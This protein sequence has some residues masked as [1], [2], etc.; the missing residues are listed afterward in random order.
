MADDTGWGAIAGNMANQLGNYAV[1][2]AANRKQYKYQQKAMAQQQQYNKDLWDYQN[3]Y[4]SP[5]Q[6]MERLKAAGLNP[7]L[8]YGSGGA[9]GGNA[10][11]IAPTEV[12]A[13]Q[14]A[15]MEMPNPVGS[16]LSARQ[17]D[18]QYKATMQNLEA[19]RVT[20]ELNQ[21]R[22]A[23]GN[24]NIMRE[25]LRSKNYKDL[26]QAEV[27]TQ[28]FVALRSGELFANEKSKGGLMDQLHEFRSKSNPK[29]IESQRLENAFKENRNRLAD[30]GIYSSDH[31]AFRVLLQ[32]AHRMG[33]DLGELLM[34]GKDNLKYLLDLVK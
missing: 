22:I 32:A 16:Y 4:N 11:P 34:K 5:Q 1:S 12:P 6:Q 30:M 21:T 24:L 20:Q 19:S 23:L 26:A 33:I 25:G 8:I 27:D 14:A 15:K 2:V 31:A 10:G 17:M 29:Q 7:R 28:K 18:A 9:S 3:A 13:Q